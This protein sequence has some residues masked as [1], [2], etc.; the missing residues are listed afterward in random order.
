MM[1]GS[2]GTRAN[3]SGL[4]KMMR[5]STF[6]VLLTVCGLSSISSAQE[7]AE[8]D[9]DTTSHSQTRGW[10]GI[11]ILFYTPETGVAG[12]AAG[13]YLYRDP[14]DRRASTITADIIYT[15]NKQ[16]MIE[17]SG[18]QYFAGGLYRLV[19]YVT[20]QKYPNTF[21]GV[22]NS[23]PDDS[24]ED[25]TP[26][27]YH[28][29]AAL[30][31]NLFSHFSVG[32]ALLLE[33]IFM[34]EREA[35]K[36]LASGALPGSNGGTTVGLGIDANWDSR[37]NTYSTQSGSFCELIF[38]FYRRPI[39][40]DYSYNDV[41]VDVRHFI[42]LFSDHVLGF[43][44]VVESIG[45]SAPFNGLAKIGGQNLMRGYFFGRYR[46]KKSLALQAEYRMPVVWRIGV[47]GF[48]SAGQVA[49]SFS[50]FGTNRFWYAGGGGLR[51]AWSP[52]ERINLRLDYGVGSGSSGMYITFSEAF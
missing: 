32:P 23:S 36:M 28:L 18:D 12:G 3:S 19:S 31:K 40:S 26:R 39:G 33:R 47:V 9:K 30:T 4:S 22:G 42:Q 38:G 46:D 14:S 17:T 1:Q 7:S 24:K 50:H 16:I 27:L 25:Y 21:W 44:G 48:A 34:V 11:P 29:D 49:D 41:R 43:Q 5:S 8:Q 20:F 52:E 51:F 2:P 6:L 35:G 13:M 15:E 10:Y 45:G 37:D